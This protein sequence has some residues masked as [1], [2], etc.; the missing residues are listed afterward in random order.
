MQNCAKQ[1]MVGV[2]LLVLNTGGV[3]RAQ[4]PNVLFIA[5]DDLRVDL[6]CYGDTQSL[7]PNIDRLASRGTL[8]T[9][10]YCQQA[11]CNPS[12][13]SML[14][15][16]R[17]ETLGIWDLPTHFR[18]RRPDAITLPQLFKQ[19]DYHTQC[20]GKI[21][22]N[23][24][25]DNYRGDAESWSV[26]EVMHYNSHGQ[27]KPQVVG[28]LPSDESGVPR[29]EMR[30]VPDEA[31]FDGRIAGLAEQ[32]LKEIGDNG[33]HF[34]LA[35]GFWKPHAPFNAPK[36]Y[37]DL[38]DRERIEMPVNPQPP[39]DVPQIALHDSREI[40]RGFK[41]NPDGK[42]TQDEARTLRHGYLAAIS[43]MDAQVGRVLAALRQNDLENNTIVVFCS[44]HGFHLG[45]HALWAKTSNF[46]LDAR[47]PLIVCAPRHPGGRVCGAI[48]ELLDIYPSL[49][50]LSGLAAPN[51]L[52]GQSFKKLLDDPTQSIKPAAFTWHPRPAYPAAGADPDAM[53]YSVRTHRYRYTQWRNYRTDDLVAEELYDHQLDANETV[54][55]AGKQGV[56]AVVARLRGLLAR[57]Q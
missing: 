15:G 34:F 52:E 23:W 5:V 20:I 48:V 25:Q 32:A 44:D 37:W 53:G 38:Y 54:N 22:H 46:E 45:E 9:H 29:T 33:R 41:S 40:L 2:I 17:P 39:T 50:D 35:V 26:A 43:Y 6:G 14:T 11:V 7:S 4:G 12:R 55:L 3:L 24:R 28:I 19:N 56:K 1:M 36:K 16:L 47:V 31:Y 51:D 27:D 49:A 8:F 57:S 13:A 21:F 18:Q 10:A 42:P 30:D